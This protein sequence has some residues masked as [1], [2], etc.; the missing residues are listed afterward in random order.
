MIQQDGVR[1]ANGQSSRKYGG[2]DGDM[3]CGVLL[4]MGHGA[5]VGRILFGSGEHG[6]HVAYPCA[7]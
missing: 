3:V 7:A 2:F 1:Q 6:H 4:R 5:Y